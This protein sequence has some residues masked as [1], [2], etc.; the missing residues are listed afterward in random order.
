MKVNYEDILTGPYADETPDG[1]N[2]C[3]Y[4]DLHSDLD[5]GYCDEVNNHWVMDIKWTSPDA[6]F[7][8]KVDGKFVSSKLNKGDTV[9]FNCVELHGLL[10]FDAASAVVKSNDAKCEEN[11]LFEKELYASDYIANE[12]RVV[13]EFIGPK[14]GL[15]KTNAEYIANNFKSIDCGK[16]MIERKEFVSDKLP[17]D[18]LIN[19]SKIITNT[20]IDNGDILFEGVDGGV[21]IIYWCQ[22]TDQE[23]NDRIAIEQ[24]H[25]DKL[26]EQYKKLKTKF[27]GNEI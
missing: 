1:F 11:V 5:N 12:C 21:N 4:M 7:V 2:C 10:P 19:K 15:T 26:I 18:A 9:A 17:L 3:S 24:S 8:H 27:E 23:V 22:E 6:L 16:K 25:N 13:W 14:C 20:F